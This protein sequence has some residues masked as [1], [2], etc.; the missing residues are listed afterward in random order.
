MM[1]SWLPVLFLCF[2]IGLQAS[3]QHADNLRQSISEAI[4]VLSGIYPVRNARLYQSAIGAYGRNPVGDLVMQSIQD[5]QNEQLKRQILD[6]LLQFDLKNSSK[7]SPVLNLLLHFHGQNYTYGPNPSVHESLSTADFSSSDTLEYKSYEMPADEIKSKLESHL[8]D[9]LQYVDLVDHNLLVLVGAQNVLPPN[10]TYEAK[11][12][13]FEFKLYRQWTIGHIAIG[14][15]P[16]E[17]FVQAWIEANP[18]DDESFVPHNTG[19]EAKTETKIET[20][21]NQ[22]QHQ[23]QVKSTW[24]DQSQDSPADGKS[25][26][27]FEA[28][29]CILAGVVLLVLAVIIVLVYCRASRSKAQEDENSN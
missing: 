6:E 22:K 18:L 11:G 10:F 8:N 13:T 26:D 9:L 25:S 15:Y 7:F 23:A 4:K 1:L 20:K 12:R 5:P 29:V 24:I 21:D 27:F 17:H 19:H 14:Y 3:D 28:V 16:G 2:R